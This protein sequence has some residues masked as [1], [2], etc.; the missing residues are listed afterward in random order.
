MCTCTRWR[1]VGPEPA[2]DAG[3]GPSPLKLMAVKDEYEVA[4]L[5]TDGRFQEAL[6]NSSMGRA[7]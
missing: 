1:W 7:A 6:T 2:V 4:R 5:Y 3:G